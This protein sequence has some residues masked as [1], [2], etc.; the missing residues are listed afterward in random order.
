MAKRTT[1]ATATDAAVSGRIHQTRRPAADPKVPG[2]NGAY[3]TPKTVASASAIRGGASRLLPADDTRACEA[4]V[5]APMVG[6]EH[7]RQEPESG[8]RRKQQPEHLSD[9]G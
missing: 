5:K 6:A 8:R 2:A 3:P 4:V 7:G 1:I 9:N